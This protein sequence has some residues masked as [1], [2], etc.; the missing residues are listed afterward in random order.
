MED[1]EILNKLIVRHPHA[2]WRKIAGETVIVTP[3]DSYMHTLNDPGAFIWSKATGD[4]TVREI[5]DELVGEFDV[6]EKT[7]RADAVEFIRDLMDKDMF[8]LHEPDDEDLPR[9]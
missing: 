1:P 2:A 8:S 7:A 4:Q 5:V 9:F 6:D 3:I